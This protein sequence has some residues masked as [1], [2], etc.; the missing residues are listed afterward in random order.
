MDLKTFFS[1]HATQIGATAA[2]WVGF[3]Q[4]QIPL[5]G[6]VAATLVAWGISNL[7]MKADAAAAAPTGAQ[8]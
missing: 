2:A 3:Y 5:S 8:S 6:A 1:S 7:H 4:N